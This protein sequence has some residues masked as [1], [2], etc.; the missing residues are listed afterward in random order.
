M[1]ADLVIDLRRVIVVGIQQHPAECVQRMV[2]IVF[3][4]AG[5]RFSQRDIAEGLGESQQKGILA[6]FS[7]GQN[8]FHNIPFTT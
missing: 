5:Q 3:F 7:T 8:V 1:G 2:G 4:V 6:G